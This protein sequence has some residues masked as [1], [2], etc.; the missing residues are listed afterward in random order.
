MHND[1]SDT[2]GKIVVVFYINCN[3]DVGDMFYNHRRFRLIDFRLFVS[4]RH[5]QTDMVCCC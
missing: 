2:S 4:I 1:C 5:I 3:M